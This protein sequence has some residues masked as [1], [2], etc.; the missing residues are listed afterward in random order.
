[1][2]C[3]DIAPLNDASV[4]LKP[5]QISL[6]FLVNFGNNGNPINDG[7]FTIKPNVMAIPQMVQTSV[8]T[9]DGIAV[10]YMFSVNTN[11]KTYMFTINGGGG[12]ISVT[13]TVKLGVKFNNT[14]ICVSLN[15]F[16]IDDPVF[17]VEIRLIPKIWNLSPTSH[18]GFLL[19]PARNYWPVRN[20][21]PFSYSMNSDVPR[22]NNTLGLSNLPY[23]T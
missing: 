6:K 12:S 5:D 15:K 19:W 14:S 21:S 23:T 20:Y 2:V 22:F 17:R 3:P 1:M 10:D 4:Q 7:I 13:Y 16:D 18:P 9:A 8:T 11:D